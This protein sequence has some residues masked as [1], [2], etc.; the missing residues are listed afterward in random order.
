MAPC[1]AQ[2]V[3]QR[4]LRSE[5][6][7]KELA[8]IEKLEVAE[9][10][11][12]ETMARASE[13]VCAR[14]LD[15]VARKAPEDPAAVR[16]SEDAT[17]INASDH[18]DKVQAT[19]PITAPRIILSMAATKVIVRTK[20]CAG[21]QYERKSDSRNDLKNI[22]LRV[23]LLHIHRA[24][25]AVRAAVPVPVPAAVR[26][27]LSHRCRSMRVIRTAQ[28]D[29]KLCMRLTWNWRGWSWMES[30]FDRLQRHSD[31]NFLV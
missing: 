30:E 16:S 15:D 18:E 31:R 14:W 2:L 28:R 26:P 22:H 6:R 5:R 19:T 1:K 9:I 27:R 13:I 7:I 8:N 17:Q 21:T 4:R 10:T 25:A 29:R 11:L 3:A 20:F 23:L 12:Q 24:P